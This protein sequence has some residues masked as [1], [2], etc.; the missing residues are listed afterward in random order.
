MDMNVEGASSLILI[1][2]SRNTMLVAS[3]MHCVSKD[4][5]DSKTSAQYQ[6]EGS[7]TTPYQRGLPVQMGSLAGAAEDRNMKECMVL[8]SFSQQCVERISISH[9]Y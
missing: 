6:L 3:E 5:N 8:S 9:S 1:R 4:L 2:A 7:N